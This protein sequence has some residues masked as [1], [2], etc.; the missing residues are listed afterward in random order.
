MNKSNLKPTCVF[1]QFAKI[2]QI[3]R[4]SKREER[5]ID[6]LKDFGESRGFET[7]VDETGNVLIRKA[8][9]PGYE[10]RET[11]I[12][13]SHMDMVCEKL[14]DVDFDF[15]KDA[16][17]TYV[18]GEWLKAKGTTLGAD[19]GIGCAIELAILDSNDIEHG[20]LE[21]VFT[22]DEETGLTGAEGMQSG[23]MTGN[24]LINLDSE[25]E[26]QIFVSCAGGRNTTA[27]F[28]FKKEKAPADLFFIKA[29]LKGL[30][31]GHSGDDINKKRANAIKIL[32]R[33]LYQTQ[34][35][36]G[37][38][39]ASFNGGKLHNA[40][41]RD[42]VIVF[43]VAQE[44]KEQVRADWNVFAVQIE[45]EYHVTE[46]TMQFNMESTDA[47]SVMPLE[48]STKLIQALQAVD[49]GVFAMCQD[50]ELAW[51][52]ETSNNVA[53]VETTA[54]EVRIV[55]SQRSNVMSALDNQAATIKAVFQLAGAD[56]VQ[57]DGYPAWKM[58]PNSALTALTVDTY[59]KLFGKNPQV[60]GIHAGLEC[61][62]FSEKYPHLDMVSFGPTLRGVH[63]PDERL[64]IPTV[65]MVWDH[66]LEILKNIPVKA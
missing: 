16:I 38:R 14:V 45:E 63:S 37:L 42:G 43:G 66:L 34:E 35:R 24:M 15:D 61:G 29:S 26:G 4:P 9:T 23:F 55:A 28:H 1:E 46:K 44:V 39:L 65:Q 13:Q 36:Y 53:S 19:D 27:T 3:P 58:N 48:T 2:N 7:I 54:D 30:I 10:N 6:F 40:I 52:V 51:L 62:L 22:R 17:Q 12:L 8:A 64:L 50:E 32:A 11:V 33:F 60:L 18:D 31:G 5:M 47:E 49:N 41:P 20:P 56:V 59:V 57:G 21:C 25:D